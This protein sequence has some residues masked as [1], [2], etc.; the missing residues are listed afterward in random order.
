MFRGLFVIVTI[1]L[2]T[3]QAKAQQQSWV[4]VEAQPTLTSAQ[5]AARRYSQFLDQVNGF[6]LGGNW[7]GIAIGP[8]AEADAE[9]LLRQL[10]ITGQIPR[11]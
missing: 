7:Y 3:L 4:Q 8:F 6:Y 11:D 2:G 1:L 9:S 5:D 10:R